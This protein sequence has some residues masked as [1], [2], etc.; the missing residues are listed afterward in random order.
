MRSCAV[1]IADL[2]TN[3]SARLARARSG[4]EIVILDQHAPIAP[5]HSAPFFLQ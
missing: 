3:L 2:K 4:E 1:G 5:T